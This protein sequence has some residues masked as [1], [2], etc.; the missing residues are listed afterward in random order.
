M[1]TKLEE[2]KAAAADAWRVDGEAAWAVH[3]A[4]YNEDASATAVAAAAWIPIKAT[5]NAARDTYEAE[6]KKTQKE[7]KDENR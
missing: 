3:V 4:W 5:Y 2:L 6:L 7:T 1:T